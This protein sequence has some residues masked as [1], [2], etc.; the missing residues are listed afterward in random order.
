M[1]NPITVF[2]AILAVIVAL[3]FM[4]APRIAP[5]IAPLTPAQLL[6]DEVL[7]R[8]K[9]PLEIKLRIVT[10]EE[11][12]RYVESPWRL[13]GMAIINRNPCEILIPDHW[14]IRAYPAAGRAAFVWSSNGDTL[15]HE[16]LHCIAGHWHKD[17]GNVWIGAR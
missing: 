9:A 4:T 15:A 12:G 2:A 7:V 14:Y 17:D 3:V 5:E 6:Q 8:I 16:I 1:I 13:R 11:M 10:R